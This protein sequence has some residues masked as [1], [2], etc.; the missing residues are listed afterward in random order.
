M[1]VTE[2]IQYR[3]PRLREGQPTLQQARLEINRP[4]VDLLEISPEARRLADDAI[5]VHEARKYDS[6]PKKPS[7]APDNYIKMEDLMKRFEPETYS[8]FQE[9]MKQSATEGLSIL[10]KFAKQIPEHPNWIK[11]YR[12]E[13]EDSRSLPEQSK[14]NH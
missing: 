4:V 10:L 5:T 9:A 2:F 7:A 1:K 12:E 11:T 8:Q 13:M 3:L 6:L 14:R